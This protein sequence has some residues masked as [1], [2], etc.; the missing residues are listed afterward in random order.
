MD[1]LRRKAQ[2]AVRRGLDGPHEDSAEGHIRSTIL[3]SPRGVVVEDVTLEF[4]EGRVASR[5]P[6]AATATCRGRS[7][8]TAGHAPGRAGIGTNSASTASSARSCSTRRSAGPSTSRSASSYPETGG[9]NESVGTGPICDL[10]QGGRAER[11][12]RHHLEDGQFLSRPAPLSRSWSSSRSPAAAAHRRR[13]AR[14]TRSRSTSSRR[15]RRRRHGPGR[16]A[17]VPARCS[18]PCVLGRNFDFDDPPALL[19]HRRRRRRPGRRRSS[20][21]PSRRRARRAAQARRSAAAR[22]GCCSTG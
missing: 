21:S 2:H 9:M 17:A 3:T 20:T 4:R 19:L 5:A 14:S 1:H 18:P 15:R 6:S 13:C 12:R 22:R 7:T 8:P 10:R 11:G 16:A